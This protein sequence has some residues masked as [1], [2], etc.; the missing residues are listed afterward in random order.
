[1]TAA[2]ARSENRCAKASSAVT[3]LYD[4]PLSGASMIITASASSA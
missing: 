4:L 1:M 3:V 2:R